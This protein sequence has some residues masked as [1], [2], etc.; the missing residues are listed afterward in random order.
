M[1]RTSSSSSLIEPEI[2]VHAPVPQLDFL[3]V[4]KTPEIYSSSRRAP[5]RSITAKYEGP[6]PA[7]FG[8]FSSRRNPRFTSRSM[9]DLA[10]ETPPGEI[11]PVDGYAQTLERRSKR[12]KMEQSKLVSEFRQTSAFTDTISEKL[13]MYDNARRLKVLVH[14]KDYEDH[15][16]Y[17]LQKRIKEKLATDNYHNYLQKKAIMISNIDRDP[18]PIHSNPRRLAPVPRMT[19][20]T[21]GLRDPTLKYLDHREDEK[22]LLKVVAKAN[23]QKYEEKKVP[24]P[25]TM[26]YKKLEMNCQTR[27]F[28]G[29]DPQA[30]KKGRKAF[31]CWDKSKVGNELDHF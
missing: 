24:P 18:V 15:F 3:K 14:N 23:G 27:F 13:Q 20:S 25:D 7:L 17:P 5:R 19:F 16:I 8:G 29:D 2:V 22:R 30:N 26:N 10:D 28:F 21:K 1:N 9:R 12:S 4:G 31:E 6:D 11:P